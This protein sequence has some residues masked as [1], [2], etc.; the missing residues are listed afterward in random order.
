M[1]ETINGTTTAKPKKRHTI[2]TCFK[3]LTMTLIILIVLSII[4]AKMFFLPGYLQQQIKLAMA[5]Y[6]GGSVEIHDIDLNLTSSAP[7]VINQITL[8]DQAKQRW[9]YIGKIRLVFSN[10]PS[11]HPVL[12]AIEIDS[13]DIQIYRVDGQYSPPLKK[14]ADDTGDD[15]SEVLSSYVDIRNIDIHDFSFSTINQD[16]IK[17]CWNEIQASAVKQ[18]AVYNVFLNRLTYDANCNLTASGTIDPSNL[19]T[20]LS[21][22][23][24]YQAQR[25]ETAEFFTALNIPIVRQAEG[26]LMAS[27]DV[28]GRLDEPEKLQFYGIA[29]LNDWNVWAF[30]SL[31]VTNLNTVVKASGRR[32]DIQQLTAQTIDGTISGNLYTNIPIGRPVEV[33]GKV[34]VEKVDLNK[35]TDAITE[36]PKITRG[37]GT[38]HYAFSVQSTG[39][40][41]L[42]GYGML[43]FDNAHL[44]N[45]PVI[46]QVFD[47]FKINSRDPLSTSD[48]IT[49]FAMKGPNTIFHQAILANSISAIEMEPGGKVNLQ[50]SQIDL[51]VVGVP[52]KTLRKIIS[53][54]PLIKLIIP[55]RDKFSRIH[56]RGSWNDS[57]SALIFKEPFKKVESDTQKVFTDVAKTGGQFSEDTVKVFKGTFDD[58]ARKK[59]ISAR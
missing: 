27:L 4:A 38:A 29:N 45:L 17:K 55:L 37:I 12:T 19:E 42:N 21:M 59:S 39:L 13:P 40:N 7:I 51:F 43:F 6:W 9:L 33:G 2:W 25:G 50:T 10:W 53:A 11:L 56:M 54:I 26:K 30:H 52:L 57:A 20:R 47:Q 15:S 22:E 44:W 48:L 23:L 5:D 24:A 36:M 49:L 31:E 16:G 58:L 41:S 1:T 14:P 18:G 3:R 34:S 46:L 35:L 8:L 28:S 32:L